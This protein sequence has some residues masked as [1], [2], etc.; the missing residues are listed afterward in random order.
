VLPVARQKDALAQETD[1]SLAGW[2][3]PVPDSSRVGDDHWPPEYV[4]RALPLLVAT[5]NPT[6]GQDTHD[7]PS[8]LSG[9]AP[10]HVP[11][12]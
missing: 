2:P 5:Q 4:Y 1:V 6:V 7:K 3:A 12:E 10:D 11:P 8:L 9:V